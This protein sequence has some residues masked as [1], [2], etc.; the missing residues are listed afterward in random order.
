MFPARDYR[1]L[2]SSR[3]L[4]VTAY[5]PLR[6]GRFFFA[7]NYDRWRSEQAQAALD[8]DRSYSVGALPGENC[9]PL[10]FRGRLAVQK[11]GH[12]RYRRG[13][14]GALDQLLDC[15]RRLEPEGNPPEFYLWRF[16]HN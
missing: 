2:G 15:P 12:W 1:P 16:R 7:E 14:P 13:Q 11:H 9:D 5:D 6:S 8:Y 4:A 10:G 3:A